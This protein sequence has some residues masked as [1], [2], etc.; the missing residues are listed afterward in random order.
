MGV[1]IRYDCDVSQQSTMPSHCPKCFGPDCTFVTSEKR[2]LFPICKAKKGRRY[3]A[4]NEKEGEEK[5]SSY[6]TEGV[7]SAC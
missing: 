1:D 5:T 2:G 3:H 7:S 4:K 6:V